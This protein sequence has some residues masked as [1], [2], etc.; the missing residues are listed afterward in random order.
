MLKLSQFSAF[1]FCLLLSAIAISA[2]PQRAPAIDE[3]I[4]LYK[5]GEYSRAATLLSVA[6]KASK[7]DGEAFYYLGAA[8]TKTGNLKQARKSLQ[9]AA[10]LI[11][12][13]A[14][15]L[16]GLANVELKSGKYG[17]AERYVRQA[18]ALKQNDTEAH[19]LLAVIS[20]QKGNRGEAIN[21]ADQI[22]ALE[23]NFA[24]A[25]VL[26]AEA[27][28]R[29]FDS[30][31][32]WISLKNSQKSQIFKNVAAILEKYPNLAENS[33]EITELRETLEAYRFFADHF[34]KKSDDN[35][36]R[37]QP[38]AGEE[39]LNILSQPRP[40]YTED[41][42]Q[43]GL[44]GEIRILVLFDQDGTVKYAM[45]LNNLPFGLTETAVTAAKK[46]SFKP[47]SKNGQPISQV[48]LIEYRFSMY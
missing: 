12:Q 21:N 11:P 33:P 26:K 24:P 29:R 4:E 23:P 2:Q 42:R 17:E 18:I 45:P 48:K 16:K 30:V 9:K 32:Q 37:P 27:A 8:E 25:Y 36:I 5:K 34:G 15:P 39:P 44:L 41:A 38:A 46:I 6:V 13:D 10:K 14:R 43:K 40:D 1:F 20:L 28:L 22:I 3:G 19:Y 35:G 47:A 31:E 7:N